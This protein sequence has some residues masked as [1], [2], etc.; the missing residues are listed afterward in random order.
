MLMQNK[1]SRIVLASGS[2]IRATLLE[3]AGLSFN[4]HPADIDENAIKTEYM[5]SPQAQMP[6]LA[7]VLSEQ[8]A[9]AVSQIYPDD[10]IIGADQI[11]VLNDTIFG[12]PGSREKTRTQLLQLRGQ[13]HHL[14]SAVS[15]V[16]N[17]E[18]LWSHTDQS[19]MKMRRFSQI[20]LDHYLEKC[21]EDIY[22][23]VG[24]Y[25]L[26]SYGAQLFQAVRGD[27]FTILGLPL[28]P[29][30]ESLR[31]RNVLVP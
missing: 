24:G 21:G 9:R 23:C 5:S 15:L 14:I 1:D 17:G 22:S 30:L 29:L 19:E 7:R 6:E 31:T 2:R 25:Q 20:F 26:E 11:L 3:K 28:I 16:R 4:V 18:T 13:T 8:K 10:Y 12:K 27:Y